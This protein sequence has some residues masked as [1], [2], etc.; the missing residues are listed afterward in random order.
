MKILLVKNK[1]KKKINWKKGIDHIHKNTPIKL[2]IEEVSTDWDLE[3]RKV[4]NGAFTGCV[5]DNY[6]DKLR[7]IAPEGKYDVICLVY[8]NKAPNVRVSITESTP[9]YSDCDVMQV[10]KMTD[11]GKTF[12]HELFHCLFYKLARRGIRLQ[13]CMDTYKNDSSLELEI[14]SNRNDALKLLAPYWKEFENPSIITKVIDAITP[15]PIYIYFNPKTDPKM[16]GIKDELMK[17]L[18]LIRGECGFPI[19]ITSGVR[20]KEENDAL[21]DSASNSGHLRGW[22]VDIACTD[23]GRRD[24]I[25]ELSYKYGITRRGIGK[26]FVHLGIDPSLAQNVTWTY[27]K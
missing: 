7:S 27:Y 1:Y 8:G 2:E 20:T 23:S 12:N 25:L 3:F 10:V 14:D 18:D 11:S 22:E 13:D 15:K 5:V 21:K 4:S 9:L 26:D 19:S 24:K 17:K 16:I 6:Y